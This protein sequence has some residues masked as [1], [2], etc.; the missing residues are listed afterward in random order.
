MPPPTHT[1]LHPRHPSA[2]TREELSTVRRVGCRFVEERNV[3]A[4]YI[5]TCVGSTATTRLR[6]AGTHAAPHLNFH[7]SLC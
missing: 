5:Q 2:T 6:P 1:A 4:A 3:T 7:L